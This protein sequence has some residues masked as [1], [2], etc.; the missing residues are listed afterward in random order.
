MT[1]QEPRL[2]IGTTERI[3]F[4]G[5]SNRLIIEKVLPLIPPDLIDSWHMHAL[6]YEGDKFSDQYTVTY[7]RENSLTGQLEKASLPLDGKKPSASDKDIIDSVVNPKR[8]SQVVANGTGKSFEEFVSLI[9]S[10]SLIEKP[11]IIHDGIIKLKDT[12]KVIVYRKGTLVLINPEKHQGNEVCKNLFAQLQTVLDQESLDLKLERFIF[13]VSTNRSLSHN[14]LATA[15]LGTLGSL[16]QSGIFPKFTSV[17]SAAYMLLEFLK[18]GGTDEDIRSL[19]ASIDRQE[20]ALNAF[21]TT[22]KKKEK[23]KKRRLSFKH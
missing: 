8:P 22:E 6:T 13:A 11:Y 23:K 12:S 5:I 20:F 21:Q 3:T 19:Q 17:I 4:P 10:I 15:I 16:E 18:W 9:P 14:T 7:F 2:H 1:E